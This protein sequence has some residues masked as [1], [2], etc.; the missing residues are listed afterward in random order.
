MLFNSSNY[1]ETFKN[2]YFLSFFT[3]LDENVI[4]CFWELPQGVRSCL[5]NNGLYEFDLGVNKKIDFKKQKEVKRVL[6]KVC[7]NYAHPKRVFD[8][9]NQ[10]L[11]D[12]N[13]Y[14]GIK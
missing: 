1:I 8:K 12:R 10:Y 5:I 14:L 9:I 7:D 6:K 11:N 2:T 13:K 3:K 4:K